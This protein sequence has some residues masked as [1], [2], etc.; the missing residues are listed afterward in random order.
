MVD[1]HQLGRKRSVSGGMGTV[2]EGERGGGGGGKIEAKEEKGD[3]MENKGMV[4]VVE[5][6]V[7]VIGT[8]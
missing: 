4:V 3:M 2:D 7:G 6:G 5:A 8:L 1:D